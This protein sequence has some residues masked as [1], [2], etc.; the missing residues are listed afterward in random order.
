MLGA[1]AQQRRQACTKFGGRLRE[2]DTCD[3]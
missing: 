2:E 3:A 1:P